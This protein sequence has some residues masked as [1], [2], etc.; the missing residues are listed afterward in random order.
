[1][2]DLFVAHCSA[3]SGRPSGARATEE[4]QQSAALKEIL[5]RLVRRFSKDIEKKW[6]ENG[7]SSPLIELKDGERI[8]GYTALISVSN[9]KIASISAKNGYQEDFVPYSA[10][11]PGHLFETK[12]FLRYE[13][14]EYEISV[15]ENETGHCLVTDYEFDGTFF[16]TSEML[17]LISS[18]VQ[19]IQEQMLAS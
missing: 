6:K 17:K 19:A 8:I 18:S 1:M 5:D 14:D 7:Y 16:Q 12:S 11:K 4:G 13:A 9:G 15:H 10:D 2:N 3:E